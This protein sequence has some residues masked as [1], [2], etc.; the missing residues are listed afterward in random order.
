MEEL[1][2]IKAATKNLVDLTSDALEDLGS[3]QNMNERLG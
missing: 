2:Q 3:A 1:K